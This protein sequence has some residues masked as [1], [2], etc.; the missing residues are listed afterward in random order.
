MIRY[1]DRKEALTQEEQ[2]ELFTRMKYGDLEARQRLILENS[3]LVG[4]LIKA[5]KR[6]Y[7]TYDDLYQEGMIGLIKAVDSYNLDC[8]TPFSSYARRCIRNNLINMS[9]RENGSL[10]ITKA[11]LKK[12][13][14]YN[15]IVVQFQHEFLRNP[16]LD[17]IVEKMKMYAKE[18][19]YKWRINKKVVEMLPAIFSEVTSFNDKVT[20]DQDSLDELLDFY[21]SDDQLI[22]DYFANIDE[23][24]WLLELIKTSDFS[25]TYLNVIR[26]R[27]GFYC[28]PHT[29]QAISKVLGI[30]LQRAGQIDKKVLETLRK[31]AKYFKRASVA[32]NCDKPKQ[33]VKK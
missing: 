17:E 5:F 4:I 9:C 31:R 2:A 20:K 30:S 1:N 22:D 19:N 21:P 26:L 12:Y 3:G 7:N 25:E 8:G 14:V 28:E 10:D 32:T 24:K 6:S 18:N 11:M 23:C 13:M 27:Y 16:T 29:L 33:I 15:E